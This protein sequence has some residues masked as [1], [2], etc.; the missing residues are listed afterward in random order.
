[1]PKS[2]AVQPRAANYR[3]NAGTSITTAWRFP[4]VGNND[5]TDALLRAGFGFDP[6]N[7]A[8]GDSGNASRFTI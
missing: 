3:V 1:M 7:P 8:H 2:S 4:R 5:F 6:D